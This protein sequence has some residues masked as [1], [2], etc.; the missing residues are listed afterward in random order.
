MAQYVIS[1][2]TPM[3]FRIDGMDRVTLDKDMSDDM[4]QCDGCGRDLADTWVVANRPGN[5][6]CSQCGSL[7]RIRETP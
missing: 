3:Y 6:K 5:L 7:F 1:N 2:D 4:D